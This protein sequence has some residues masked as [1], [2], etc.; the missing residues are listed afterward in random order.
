MTIH[1]V[2]FLAPAAFPQWYD[3][4]GGSVLVTYAYEW[5]TR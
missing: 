1:Q 4:I 3:G 5:E 2:L